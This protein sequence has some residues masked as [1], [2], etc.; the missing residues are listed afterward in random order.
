MSKQSERQLGAYISAFMCLNGETPTLLDT[1][2]DVSF[3]NKVIHAGYVPSEAEAVSFGEVVKNNIEND[4]KLLREIC[5]SALVAI[6]K[7]C[8]YV[9]IKTKLHLF[10]VENLILI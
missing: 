7:N 8:R 3:R 9:V 10:G 6:Y 1:N 5:P 4:I 2:D